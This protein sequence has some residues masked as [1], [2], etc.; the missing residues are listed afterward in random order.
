MNHLLLFKNLSDGVATELSSTP[1]IR[2]GK[3]YTKSGE[4]RNIAG[5]SFLI[6]CW[7]FAYF[8][9]RVSVSEILLALSKSLSATLSHT[10]RYLDPVVAL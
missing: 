2:S 6:S 5:V 7:N 9:A 1:R 3:M 8:A 10:A 4:Y